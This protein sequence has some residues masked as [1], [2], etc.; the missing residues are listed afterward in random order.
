MDRIPVLGAWDADLLAG[1]MTGSWTHP[2]RWPWS[3]LTHTQKDKSEAKQT[4]HGECSCP[5]FPFRL[6]AHFL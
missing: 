1:L 2:H 6:I 5:G 3:L 4:H